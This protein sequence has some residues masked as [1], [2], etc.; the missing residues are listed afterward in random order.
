MVAEGSVDRALE[1]RHYYRSRPI[2][3]RLHKQ[4]F[5]AFLKYRIVKHCDISLFNENY[6][7]A[8]ELLRCDPTPENLDRLMGLDLFNLLCDEMLTT[9]GTQLKMIVEY[10]HGVSALLTIISSVREL[11]IER[12][13]QAERNI[14]PVSELFTF[15]HV[16]YAR[17][18][19]NLHVCLQDLNLESPNAWKER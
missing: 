8:P 15:G 3:P 14:L 7:M 6:K 9:S 12:H 17:Y 5:K 13:P 11:S 2:G 10:I 18:L 19:T 16:N 4:S 1:G